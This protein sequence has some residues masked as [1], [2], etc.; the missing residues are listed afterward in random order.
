MRKLIRNSVHPALVL[1]GRD[2]SKEEFKNAYS[3]W[4]S[5]ERAAFVGC[6]LWYVCNYVAMDIETPDTLLCKNFM[7][8]TLIERSEVRELKAAA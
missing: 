2:I 5:G 8:A 1:I 4:R 3:L 6:D 7:L